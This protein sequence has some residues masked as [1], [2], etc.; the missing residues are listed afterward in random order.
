MHRRPRGRVQLVEQARRTDHVY[1][2]HDHDPSVHRQPEPVGLAGSHRDVAVQRRDRELLRRGQPRATPGNKDT[3]AAPQVTL[4]DREKSVCYVLGPVLLAPR[5]ISS[6][7]AAKNPTGGWDVT[8]HFGNDDFV[9]RIGRPLLGK[10]VA[11]VFRH[12]VWSAPVIQEELT[13]PDARISGNLDEQ[14]AR[15]LANAL[16]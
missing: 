12:V 13:T 11:I 4:S 6:A 9:K 7:V 8:V 5:N 1:H 16:R 2:R 14:S 10:N 3:L 15:E